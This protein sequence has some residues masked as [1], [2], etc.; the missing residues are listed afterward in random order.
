MMPILLAQGNAPPATPWQTYFVLMIL[1]IVGIFIPILWIVGAV[2][3]PTR[4][5]S[6]RR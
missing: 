2:L 5:S 6:H 4:T 3:P 1:G